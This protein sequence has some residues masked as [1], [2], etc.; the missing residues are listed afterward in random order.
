MKFESVFYQLKR[1]Q[2]PDEE[3][4]IDWNKNGQCSIRIGSRQFRLNFKMKKMYRS[5][6][7]VEFAD[8]ISITEINDLKRFLSR[9]GLDV[10]KTTAT[11]RLKGVREVEILFA[12]LAQYW[13]I[14]LTY[15]VFRC[16][17]VSKTNSGFSLKRGK[18][19]V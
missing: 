12:Y 18:P 14:S 17:G 15:D 10:M 1:M 7:K 6:E 16:N 2:T 13:G 19:L 11:R 4:S 8:L 9:Y 3:F 5:D